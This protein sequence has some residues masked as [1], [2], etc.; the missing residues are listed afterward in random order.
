VT[1]RALDALP[2]LDASLQAA[3]AGENACV[4]AYGLIGAFLSDTLEERARECLDA[5]QASR[6][7]VRARLLELQAQPTPAAAAYTPPFPVTDRASA[8][9]LAALVEDRLALV[10]SDVV[11][12]AHAAGDET[13]TKVAVAEVA[14]SAVRSTR[15]S[16]KTAAFPGLRSAP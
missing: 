9:R 2:G 5:H 6:D 14:A 16:G 13:A 15:W 12:S 3:L 1:G 11:A 7:R 4:Y 8:I 10:W